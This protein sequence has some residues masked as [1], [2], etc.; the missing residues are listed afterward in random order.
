MIADRL[1][2]IEYAPIAVVSLGYRKNEIGDP[3]H[4]FG[5]LLPRSAGIRTLG[6]VWNTSLFPNRAPEGHAL[7]TSFVGG[8]TDPRCGAATPDEF[9]AHGAQG[10]LS[11]IA[12]DS[13]P[14]RYFSNVTIYPHAL[15]QYNLGHG[16]RSPPSMRRVKN[17][18]I[19]GLSETT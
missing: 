14:P 7:L 3:L 18:Q 17:I 12:Q 8:A 11:R 4:G 16:E 9:S 2:E 10:N 6:T 19:S 13:Q 15:P 1:A 5:F